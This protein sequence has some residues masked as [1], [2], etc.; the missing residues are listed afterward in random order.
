MYYILNILL[1]LSRRSEGIRCSASSWTTDLA[2]TKVILMYLNYMSVGIH[3][4]LVS[5]KQL[6]APYMLCFLRSNGDR[7]ISCDGMTISERSIHI[8][9]VTSF[10]CSIAAA[11]CL[12]LLTLTRLHSKNFRAYKSP[13]GI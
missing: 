9:N 5:L 8:S 7:C 11:V 4:S 10:V 2:A 13:C 6:M 1:W 3:N 12:Q